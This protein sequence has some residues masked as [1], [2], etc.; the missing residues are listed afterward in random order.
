LPLL[1]DK[2]GFFN[3]S[4]STHLMLNIKIG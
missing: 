3:P 1:I 2:D 4:L